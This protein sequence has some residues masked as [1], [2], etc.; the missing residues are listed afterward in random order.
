MLQTVHCVR[1][2]A[3]PMRPHHALDEHLREI[4]KHARVLQFDQRPGQRVTLL[5]GHLQHPGRIETLRLKGKLPQLYF[6]KKSVQSVQRNTRS[7][8]GKPSLPLQEIADMGQS[9]AWCILFQRI[10]ARLP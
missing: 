4:V 8:Q 9:G 10:P 6:G 3:M 5:R 7:L 1:L 2:P